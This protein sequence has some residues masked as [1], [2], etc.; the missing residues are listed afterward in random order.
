MHVS[1]KFE[2]L[3]DAYRRPDGSKWTGQ[4]LDEAT[5]GVVTRSYVTNLRKGRI[6]NPGYEKMRMM[7][8]A[9]G[10]PPEAWF[11][12]ISADG[13]WS[14]RKEGRGVAGRVEHLF[15]AVVHPRSGEPYTS[16]EVARMSAGGLTEGEVEGIRTGKISDPTVGQVAALTAVFGV[17][18]SYLVNREEPPP[19]DAELL[20][21][22]SDETTR[23]ITREALRLPERERGIVLGVVR[24]FASQSEA[25]DGR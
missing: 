3:L 17:E 20:E 24:Q 9:M 13:T 19:L 14:A 18:P 2:R 4:Q 10:F 16:A 23:E 11:E 8:K 25:E 1:Q 6:E 7:A 21:G 5:G 12:D 15:G 22:L